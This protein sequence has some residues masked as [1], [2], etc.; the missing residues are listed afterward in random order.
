MVFYIYEIPG[1]KN[2]ATKDWEG[3]SEYNF[4]KY[5][6]QPILIETM[7]GPDVEEFW[8]VVGDREWE[9]A[10]LNGYKRG[11]HY[12]SIRIRGAIGQPRAAVLGGRVTG[13]K[14][15]ES[16]HIQR[17]Q[18]QIAA[19]GGKVAGKQSRL[20]TMEQAKE[21]RSLYVKGSKNQHYKV[22][23]TQHELAKQFNTTRAVIKGIVQGLT[24]LT[25]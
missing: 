21:I 2:G 4:N 18:K 12:R 14:N 15:V 9:L 5:N 19:A 22:G 24:Y 20:L 11:E 8:Q 23:P 25:P 10:D 17:L 6:I 13:R 1:E 7:E 16:G 3:R